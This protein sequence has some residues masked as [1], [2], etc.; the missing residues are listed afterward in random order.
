MI[1]WLILAVVLL[2][3]AIIWMKLNWGDLNGFG[4]CALV[5]VVVW[6]MWHWRDTPEESA[7]KE[8]K[9]AAELLARQTPHVIREADGCKVYEFE[10]GG[11]AHFFTRCPATTDTETTWSEFCGKNCTRQKSSNIIVENK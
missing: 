11:R 3:A 7:A 2:S 9:K 10:R 5:I 6:S 8:A 1:D 4:W